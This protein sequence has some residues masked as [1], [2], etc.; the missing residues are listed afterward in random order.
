MRNFGFP[1]TLLIQDLWILSEFLPISCKISQAV[2][3]GR[4]YK[5]PR[6]RQTEIEVFQDL[7]GGGTYRRDLSAPVILAH[8][9]NAFKIY[10]Y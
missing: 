6:L 9:I 1:R 3:R 8:D 4:G 7:S 5:N 2:G 10:L